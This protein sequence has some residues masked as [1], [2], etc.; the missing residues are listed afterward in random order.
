M[1]TF[2][3]IV[4]EWQVESMQAITRCEIKAFDFTRMEGK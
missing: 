3:F 1:Q 4:Y 2:Q